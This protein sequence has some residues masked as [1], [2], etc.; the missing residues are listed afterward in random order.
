[1]FGYFY[2]SGIKLLSK[3]AVDAHSDSPLIATFVYAFGFNILVAHLV[4]KYDEHWPVIAS[5]FIGLVGLVA[6]PF[7]LFGKN[8][9]IELS[10]LAGILFSLPLSTYVVGLIK[11]KL[12][13]N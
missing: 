6:V 12:N 5:V 10:L 2:Q 7:I 1:V 9:L 8:E 11:V 13:K 3:M 4:T